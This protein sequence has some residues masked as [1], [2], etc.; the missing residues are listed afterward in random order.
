MGADFDDLFDEDEFDE[1][2]FENYELTKK[3]QKKI[4]IDK[5]T[6]FF[7][8]C[9][10]CNVCQPVDIPFQSVHIRT[11]DGDT[12]AWV[13]EPCLEERY[14]RCKETYEEYVKKVRRQ[15]A[16]KKAA[17]TRAINAAKKKKAARKPRKPRRKYK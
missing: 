15:V 17:A 6:N 9:D 2:D 7:N 4:G 8:F 13:C 3:F 11:S 16:A 14:S 10:W 5:V 1:E 12:I